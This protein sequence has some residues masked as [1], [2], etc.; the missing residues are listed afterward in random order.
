MILCRRD[1]NRWLAIAAHRGDQRFRIEG[2]VAVQLT[3]EAQLFEIVACR[4]DG[5]QFWYESADPR[6]DPATAAWLRQSLQEMAEPERLERPGLTAE[7][8]LAYALGYFPR[9]EARR[10]TERDR[11]EDRLRAALA[12]AGAELREYMEHPD[13]YRITYTVAG[14]RHVSS[15]DKRDLTVQ[16]AGICLSGQ[17]RAF[18]LQSLVGV[19]R[20]AASGGLARDPDD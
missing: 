10:Q 20:E 3:E 16:A 5:S 11:I 7:E 8:R 13:G 1:E 14:R 18:D 6:H 17:D 12:H 2:M 9:L 15:V 19:L 4:F